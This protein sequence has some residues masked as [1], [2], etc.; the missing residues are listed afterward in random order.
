MSSWSACPTG[1]TAWWGSG[2]WAL[3][4]GQKQRL[5][6]ARTLLRDPPILILDDATSS[7]DV[8]TEHLMQLAFQSL[9][10]GRTT[11]IITSRLSTISDADL[12]L[13]FKEGAIVERGTH[14]ELMAQGGEYQ[15]LYQFQLRLQEQATEQQHR[16]AGDGGRQ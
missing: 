6:L 4:G 15:R 11:F 8:Q 13:V 2:A 5:S 1:T 7:V 16:A 10:K 12:V 9:L 14:E 3:S